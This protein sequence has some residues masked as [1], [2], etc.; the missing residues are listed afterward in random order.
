MS[1]GESRWLIPICCPD[2]LSRPRVSRWYWADS[3]AASVMQFYYSV[4]FFHFHSLFMKPV[5]LNLMIVCAP[6]LKHNLRAYSSL[7]WSNVYNRLWWKQIS[8]WHILRHIFIFDVCNFV[9]FSAVILSKRQPKWRWA[10]M[11]RVGAVF[12]F[13]D[14]ISFDWNALSKTSAPLSGPVSITS[15]G[16]IPV[17]F[18]QPQTTGKYSRL[19]L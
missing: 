19:S 18:K 1:D 12:L 16:H 10:V 8:L 2:R 17:W 15:H 5:I 6:H 9:L 11:S 13:N 3:S 4:S 7:Q 14:S